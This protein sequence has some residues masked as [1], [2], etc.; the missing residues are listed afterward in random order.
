MA[1][2]D[3]RLVRN[4]SSM[5][6]IREVYYDKN[7]TPNAMTEGGVFACGDTVQQVAEDLELMAEAL[8]KPVL[9]EFDIGHEEGQ[10]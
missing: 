4:S 10:E 3:Y 9:V 1:T 6:E 2:W 8:S 7:G 5:L